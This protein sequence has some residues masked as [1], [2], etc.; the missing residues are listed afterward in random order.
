MDRTPALVCLDQYYTRGSGKFP[1]TI[2]WKN[3]SPGGECIGVPFASG[4]KELA[5]WLP[6]IRQLTDRH[7]EWIIYTD[8]NGFAGD[9]VRD[10]A[11]RRHKS[12]HRNPIIYLRLEMDESEEGYK[13]AWYKATWS[14]KNPTP[15][16]KRFATY[17]AGI[18]LKLY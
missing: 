7:L 3:I 11:E 8:E 4:G 10:W 14:P 2:E 13:G 1:K 12:T 18:P 6:K 16:L 15:T 5:K 17:T 9:Y